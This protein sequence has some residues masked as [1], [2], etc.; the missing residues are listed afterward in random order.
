[1][2]Y[3]EG[4]EEDPQEAL[5]VAAETSRVLAAEVVVMTVDDDDLFTCWTFGSGEIANQF[6]SDRTRFPAMP[7]EY[8]K[9]LSGDAAAMRK[10]AAP[11]TTRET[12]EHFLRR[13]ES[14]KEERPFP[15][16]SERAILLGELLG[17]KTEYML[18]GYRILKSEG[19]TSFKSVMRRSRRVAG[20][21]GRVSEVRMQGLVRRGDK[22]RLNAHLQAVSDKDRE[23]AGVLSYALQS[24]RDDIAKWILDQDIDLSLHHEPLIIP[25][26]QGGSVE[27]ITELLR[28]GEDVN[29]KRGCTPPLSMAA[30]QGRLE[31]VKCL[32]SAGADVDGRDA[33]GGTPLMAAAFWWHLDVVKCLLENGAD[34]RIISPGGLTALAYAKCD[35]TEVIQS[36]AFQRSSVHLPMGV[37]GGAANRWRII[38]LLTRRKS[39]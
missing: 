9:A 34:P 38:K 5:R 16:E 29:D 31:V 15:L 28:R 6:C 18:A 25:A 36:V 10:L 19:R 14:A 3:D 26:A 4:S 17:I 39:R 13:T 1:M 37:N 24:G 21:P 27:M 7:D 20:K 8:W 11:G 23:A 32:I 22:K 30:G 12:V 35:Q 33:G 2:V